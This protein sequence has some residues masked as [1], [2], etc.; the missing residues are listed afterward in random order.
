MSELDEIAG[1]LRA[2]T[3][4]EKEEADAKTRKE[5]HAVF[6]RAAKLLE[7]FD[8]SP[9]TVEFILRGLQRAPESSKASS[10]A[11]IRVRHITSRR[12]EPKPLR[13]SHALSAAREARQW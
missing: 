1:D 10:S 8:L 4:L 9:A 11:Q 5:D 7:G 6:A 2:D 13:M 3:S 12:R